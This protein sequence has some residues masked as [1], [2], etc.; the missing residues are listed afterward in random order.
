MVIDER[1][2]IVGI[3]IVSHNASE[4]IAEGALAL[5][6]GLKLDDIINTVHAFPTMSEALKIAAQSFRR[7]VTAMSC[8]VE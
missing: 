3:H 8:C 1:E 7:D 4:I 6:L 2:R 5:R